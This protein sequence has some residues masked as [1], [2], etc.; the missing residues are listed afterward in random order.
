M[1]DLAFAM[2]PPPDGA[3]SG[4]GLL[5]LLPPAHF[6]GRELGRAH[7]AEKTLCSPI[8]PLIYANPLSPPRQR[9]DIKVGAVP[10]N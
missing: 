6:R 1:L 4:G 8:K 10:D 2:A 9:E 7:Q 5:A 3:D